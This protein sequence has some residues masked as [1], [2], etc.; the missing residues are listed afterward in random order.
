MKN[1]EYYNFTIICLSSLKKKKWK[2]KNDNIEFF[3]VHADMKTKKI[4]QSSNVN[5]Y[6]CWYEIPEFILG[7][8]LYSFESSTKATGLYSGACINIIE[9]CLP[10][11]PAPFWPTPPGPSGLFTEYYSLP[12]LIPLL[13]LLKSYTPLSILSYII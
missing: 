5:L 9:S 4:T 12:T 1:K 2:N 6:Q 3:R 10:A 11:P 7:L 8:P 13:S